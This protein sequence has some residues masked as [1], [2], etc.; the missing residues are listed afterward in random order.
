MTQGYALTIGYISICTFLS[1]DRCSMQRP[2]PVHA[3][4]NGQARW[5]KICAISLTCR[6]R[7]RRTSGSE[8][9]KIEDGAYSVQYVRASVSRAG[10]RRQRRW[11][12]PDLAYVVN[13]FYGVS[14]KQF[15]RREQH[16]LPT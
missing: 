8:K 4:R 14:S 2:R 12:Q 10:T 15:Y 13:S 9:Q 5:S 3:V 7:A 11:R 6:C 1:Q 16:V